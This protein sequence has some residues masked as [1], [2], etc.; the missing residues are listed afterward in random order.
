LPSVIQRRMVRS[1]MP[2]MWAASAMV[3][4]AQFT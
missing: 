4:A 3:I 1:E 2:W